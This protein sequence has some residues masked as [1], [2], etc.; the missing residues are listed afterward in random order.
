MVTPIDERSVREALKTAGTVTE[1]ASILGVSR[2]TMYRL[3][4]KYGIEL[5][6]IWA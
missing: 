2:R 5:K 4:A 6:R 1:A 3:M